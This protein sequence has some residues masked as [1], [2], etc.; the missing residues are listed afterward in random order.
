MI[1]HRDDTDARAI[2]AVDAD[3][4]DLD[5]GVAVAD[6]DD[7]DGMVAAD[8]DASD[9][10]A[11]VAVQ[12]LAVDITAR[13]NVDAPDIVARAANIFG[14]DRDVAGGARRDS[15]R[16][17]SVGVD[18]P[19]GDAD[20]AD[21]A[22]RDD[23]ERIIA[24]GGH[25]VGV[26]HGIAGKGE[27]VDAAG[28]QA[29]GGDIVDGDGQVAGREAH[30]SA[31]VPGGHIGAAAVDDDR[32]AVGGEDDSGVARVRLDQQI[33]ADI[34]RQVAH[35]RIVDP[36]R[37]R[38]VLGAAIDHVLRGDP[39]RSGSLRRRRIGN[40]RQRQRRHAGGAGETNKGQRFWL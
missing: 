37:E 23:P 18:R 39:A 40:Q 8:L 6:P 16:R 38:R 19:C 15:V 22:L 14:G 35:H 32:A 21:A 25:A 11:G 36:V 31:R 28:D 4:V 27:G 3:P 7:A 26:D 12:R 17:I 5:G 2:V 34:D 9:L 30:D 29:V 20:V 13:G 1:A 10:D 24:A 33:V